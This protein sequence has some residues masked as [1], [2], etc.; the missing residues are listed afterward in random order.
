MN[1]RS[2]KAIYNFINDLK[3]LFPHI[4]TEISEVTYDDSFLV[5]HNYGK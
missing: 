5:Y 1:N 3:S 2:K 4:V